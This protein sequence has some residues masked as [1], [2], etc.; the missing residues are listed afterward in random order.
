MRRI[1]NESGPYYGY[2]GIAA[3]KLVEA[4]ARP[5]D[6][7]E[8]ARSDGSR[9]MGTLMPKSEFSA[10]DIVVLKLDNGYNVGIRIDEGAKVRVVEGGSLTTHP[11]EPV[12][13]SEEEVRPPAERVFVLGTGG[14]IASRVDYETGAVNP[15]MDSKELAAS[16]PEMFKYATVDSVQFM[17][18]FSEDMT[19]RNWQAIAEEV[20]RYFEKGYSGVVVAHGTDTMAYT[21]AALSFVFHRGLPGPVALVGAQRSSDRPSSDAAFNLTSAV[22]VASRA[23]F[24]EVCVVMHGETGDSYALAH[25][26]TKVRKMH[27]SRRDAFQSVNDVPLAKVWPYEGKIEMLKEDYRRRSRELRPENGFDDK[28]ALIKFFPGMTSDL[29][30]FLVDRGYHGIVIE[31]TGFGHVA[32]ALIPSVQ[33][34]V[35]EGIPVVITSQ[36]LFGRVNLNVY[37]TGR[38]MLQAGVIPAEDML[39]E[40]AYVKLS[41]A[42]HRTRD[43]GEV[44]RLMLTNLAGE[45]NP[46]HELK[47]FPR[48]YHDRE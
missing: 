46:R 2:T 24:G 20:A 44:R 26:G 19:P 10:P 5:G 35:E 15:Y 37:S 30:D 39:P 16:V 41:W 40:T 38:R 36:T 21:A 9:L 28:V 23:P 7:V 1:S 3:K 25:R 31:G 34:A 29:I 4:S 32:N 13:L 14:T 43:L 18:I 47:L 6:V 12:S 27:T 33:R 8:V 11:G 42:L 22:L 48:W 17:S 45:I